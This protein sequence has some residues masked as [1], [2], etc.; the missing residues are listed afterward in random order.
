MLLLTLFLIY[1]IDFL[2]KTPQTYLINIVIIIF[3]KL[4]R[5]FILY[6]TLKGLIPASQSCD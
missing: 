4:F 6:V 5:F 1:L 2:I 3:S